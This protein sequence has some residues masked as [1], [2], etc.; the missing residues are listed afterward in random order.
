MVPL[1]RKDTGGGEP[2]WWFRN[3]GIWRSCAGGVCDGKETGSWQLRWKRAPRLGK[4]TERKN[5]EQNNTLSLIGP[6]YSCRGQSPVSVGTTRWGGGLDQEGGGHGRK[7][8]EVRLAH[9]YG[10]FY[11]RGNK[12]RTAAIQRCET[13]MPT[14]LYLRRVAGRF[15]QGTIE[16]TDSSWPSALPCLFR[17]ASG[18]YHHP[19]GMADHSR[20]SEPRADLRNPCANATHP[21]GM[22]EA[23]PEE[24]AL[25][26]WLLLAAYPVGSDLRRDTSG[27]AF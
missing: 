20:R 10:A 14:A 5:R 6:R 8:V 2:P 18:R 19:A 23:R 25:V 3:Y 26:K 7:G 21:G 12:Q 22:P 27:A 9:Q 16:D 11:D 24:E 15:T 1:H 13:S 4:G 17:L